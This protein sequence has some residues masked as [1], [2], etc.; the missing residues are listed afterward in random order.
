MFGPRCED[1]KLPISATFR[2]GACSG[3]RK[4]FVFAFVRAFRVDILSKDSAMA[5]KTSNIDLLAQFGKGSGKIRLGGI[6]FSAKL[7]QK[8]FNLQKVMTM[9]R[10]AA[11]G[12]AQIVMTP[13]CALS[14]F[15]NTPEERDIAETIPGPAT[16]QLASLA[17]ELGIYLL[18]GMPEL[19]DDQFHNAMA[20]IGKDGLLMGI[21]RKVHLNKYE[22]PVGWRNG[23]EFPVWRFETE[24]GVMSGGIMI[25]YDREPPESARSLMVKGADVI[26][27]PLATGCP[28]VDIHRCLLRTRAFE[29]ALYIFMV[30]HAA[31]TH[32]GHSMGIDY[33]GNIVTEAGEDEKLF[34]Y[35]VDLDALNEF[36]GTTI[37]G[38]RHRRP[39]LYGPLCDPKGQVHVKGANL[40]PGHGGG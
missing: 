17:K 37:Y 2:I 15:M 38:V 26:F 18:V 1:E 5:G 14:G 39:E 10:Q 12:G 28:V 9:A 8:D 16:D 40:P 11:K 3:K 25:C 7:G 33:D 32:N 4:L 31:P 21:F 19:K 35:D 24:T 20:V 23:S 27:N 6:Q 34:F 13:E 22:A 36:R 29:N 30:N